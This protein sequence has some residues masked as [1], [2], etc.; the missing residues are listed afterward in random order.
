MAVTRFLVRTDH[1]TRLVVDPV[2]GAFGHD[3]RADS[4][5]VLALPLDDHS[6]FLTRRD[7]VSFSAM[8]NG[9]NAGPL[10]SCRLAADGE[11]VTLRLIPGGLVTALPGG[12]VALD[13]DT[14]GRWE[15]FTLEPERA[16]VDCSLLFPAASIEDAAT[17]GIIANRLAQADPETRRRALA[18]LAERPDIVAIFVALRRAL[19]GG[20]ERS[21]WH[22]RAHLAAGIET[23]GWQIGD[24]TYGNPVI[25]D[26]EYAPL[27]IGRY[28]SIAG[29]VQIVLANHATD[30]VTTYPFGALARFWPSAPLRKG[31]DHVGAGVAIGHSV[32]LGQG[33]TI[34]P[35]SAIG[36]GAII[37][38]GSVVAGLVP[39]FAVAVGNP[40]RVVRV[41]FNQDVV[42]RLLTAA[43]WNWPDEQV[44]QFIPLLLGN[45]IEAFLDRAGQWGGSG[46]ASPS[47]VEGR[48]PR[49]SEKRNVVP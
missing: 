19:S 44:D 23:H 49:S 9:A 17:P 37:G 12:G 39:P 5:E 34:L 41:R 26:G 8:P 7:G 43:W 15:R 22:T 33:V 40:A 10:L 30:S 2:T 46:V 18:S 20:A 32:W 29:G 48:S 1:G 21:P 31:V 4:V 28:C 11:G 6:C 35:G 45:D 38:A 14:I 25:V 3:D 27:S 42:E 13:R 16:D 47:G 24:H 36:D